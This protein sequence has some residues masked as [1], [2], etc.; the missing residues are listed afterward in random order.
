[1]HDS[2]CVAA[3]AGKVM[4]FRLIRQNRIKAKATAER[5]LNAHL[6]LL[7]PLFPP[8]LQLQV[9]L[10]FVQSVCFPTGHPKVQAKLLLIIY[11]EY[12]VT[13]KN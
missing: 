4:L 12:P 8:G 3:G 7:L 2:S 5:V 11:C 1:M 13:D 9:N 10:F 6:Y